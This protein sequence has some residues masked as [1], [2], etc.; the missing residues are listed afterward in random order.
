MIDAVD[1]GHLD[2]CRRPA[3]GRPH[4]AA[5][6]AARAAAKEW[7]HIVVHAED[8]TLLVN[9]S[10]SAT[11]HGP[12]ARVVVM[13]HL[14]GTEHWVASVD[15]VAPDQLV[16]ATDRLDARYGAQTSFAFTEGTYHLR[17]S[18]SEHGYAIDLELTPQTPGA[19]LTGVTLSPDERLSWFFAPRLTASGLVSF[20]PNTHEVIDA[21]AYHDHNWGHFDWGGDY[22]WEW[23]SVVNAD[24]SVTA[25][26]LMNGARTR[27]TSQFL[28][29]E[30]AAGAVTFRDGEIE[31][32]PTGRRQFD[33]AP[34][35]P[36]AMRLLTPSLVEDVPDS[37]RW[38]ARRGDNQ[39]D[40]CIEPSAVARLVVPSER[41][42]DR[43]VVLA[44]VVGNAELTA[45]VAGNQ[46]RGGGPTILELL[47]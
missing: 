24:W 32:V 4:R 31:A 36:G 34:V 21:L 30:T 10:E 18:S 26:R 12:V 7:H 42:V 8:L 19:M 13:A 11:S 44:E 41:A 5:T 15:T 46:I 29:L 38:R 2:R 6:P 40:L 16:I 3:I 35:V 27:I 23:I 14:A 25:S 1:L 28:H 39:V 22:A 9:L 20:G 33:H 17:S 45:T 37:M 47:R 43:V